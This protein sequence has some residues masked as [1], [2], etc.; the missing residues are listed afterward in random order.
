MRAG[1]VHVQL[2]EPNRNTGVSRYS[3]P[4]SPRRA[5]CA[6]LVF[7]ANLGKFCRFFDDLVLSRI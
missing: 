4:G 6:G 5:L 1:F 2:H 7:D 3:R